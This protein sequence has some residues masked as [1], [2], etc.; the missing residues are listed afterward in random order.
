MMLG[1]LSHAAG[2]ITS[3]RCVLVTSLRELLPYST[4]GT[5]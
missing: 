3:E 1:G 2:Q 4:V 5:T